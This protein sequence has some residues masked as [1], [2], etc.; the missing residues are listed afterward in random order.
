MSGAVDRALDELYDLYR[1]RIDE[2]RKT[3]PPPDWDGVFVATTK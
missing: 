1:E 2:Y 3:P